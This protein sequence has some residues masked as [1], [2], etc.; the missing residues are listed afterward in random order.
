MP[1]SSC[2]L[3]PIF[4]IDSG[5]RGTPYNGLCREA[6]PKM[7]TFFRVHFLQRIKSTKSSEGTV[8]Y[9]RS[10]ADNCLVS[11]PLHS[12]WTFRKTWDSDQHDGHFEWRGILVSLSLFTN[13]GNFSNVC[14]DSLF[15]TVRAPVWPAYHF[16]SISTHGWASLISRWI[17]CKNTLSLI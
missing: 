15:H 13:W 2:S 11:T 1:S 8:T 14:V 3:P 17:F 16:S 4:L 5:P 10:Q 6:P 12:I 9:F 7:V